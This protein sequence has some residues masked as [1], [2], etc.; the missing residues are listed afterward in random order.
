MIAD[1]DDRTV[2]LG[3]KLAWTQVWHLWTAFLPSYHVDPSP[4]GSATA[5]SD[6]AMTGGTGATRSSSNPGQARSLIR[7]RL[8]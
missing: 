6:A 8:R 3:P 5:R 2:T 7:T 1:S 4:A